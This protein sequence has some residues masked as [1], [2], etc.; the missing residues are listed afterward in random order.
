V[1]VTF[2]VC[3]VHVF[4][5]G[6]RARVVYDFDPTGGSNVYLSD[7]PENII[8]K[9]SLMRMVEVGQS[10]EGLGQRWG[11]RSFLIYF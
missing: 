7:L 5:S 3:A 6:E 4:P 8:E 1:D 2:E 10:V 9:M 11:E